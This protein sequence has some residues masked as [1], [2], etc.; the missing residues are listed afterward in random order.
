MELADVA[1]PSEGNRRTTMPQKWGHLA[2][3]ETFERRACLICDAPDPTYSWTD[4]S[5]EGYCTC[6]GTPY[7]LKWGELKEGESYPRLNVDARAIPMLRR[8]WTETG[9]GNGLGSFFL[10]FDTYPDQLEGR[11]GF[12]AWFDAHKEEYPEFVKEASPAPGAGGG[13]GDET[14]A[15]GVG[16]AVL[17]GRRVRQPALRRR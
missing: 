11:R 15:D 3:A 4:Y 2:N 8:Y 7:Q 16:S 5:G 12:N 14:T 6:C 9:A 13:G 10:G 17:L 1:A